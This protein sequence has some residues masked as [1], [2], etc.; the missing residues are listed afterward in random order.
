MNYD[1]FANGD[2]GYY[3]LDRNE[4]DRGSLSDLKIGDTIKDKLGND[5]KYF[6][7]TKIEDLREYKGDCDTTGCK[8]IKI[9]GCG[10]CHDES[11]F[12]IYGEII[13]PEYNFVIGRS[14]LGD[15][16]HKESR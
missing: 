15:Y 8:Y 14:F 9:S 4:D 11:D 10:T 13:E 2:N 16:A 12:F 5:L 3:W 7:V 1:F 6:K